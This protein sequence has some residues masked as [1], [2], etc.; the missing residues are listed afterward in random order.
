MADIQLY[1]LD[2]KTK[3]E[4]VLDILGNPI[5]ANSGDISLFDTSKTKVQKKKDV[6]GLEYTGQ[7]LK[8]YLHNL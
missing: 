2:N 1:S 6:S 3:K 4:P 5:R 8:I 7:I